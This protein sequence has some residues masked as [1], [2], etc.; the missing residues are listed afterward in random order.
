MSLAAFPW[1]GNSHKVSGLFADDYL[2]LFMGV[3]AKDTCEDGM[4]HLCLNALGRNGIQSH[5]LG[6]T[7]SSTKGRCLVGS[8]DNADDSSEKSTGSSIP[9]L[10]L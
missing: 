2:D 3:F 6:R 7:G 9:I 8:N 5:R 10:G 1:T 4:S